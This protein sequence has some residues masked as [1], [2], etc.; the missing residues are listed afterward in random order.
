MIHHDAT[1]GPRGQIAIP[2]AIRDRTGISPGDTVR[3][4]LED[5]H[6]VLHIPSTPAA[7]KSPLGDT[8]KAAEKEPEPDELDL[9]EE[10]RSESVRFQ[11][12][13]GGEGSH[14]LTPRRAPGEA[15]NRHRARERRDR[16]PR[17]RCSS[18]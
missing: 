16:A 14:H 8:L 18:A 15:A 4:R 9:D 17:A 7:E 6:S 3:F 13:A 10:M 12:T 11:D 1:V 5:D 2:E